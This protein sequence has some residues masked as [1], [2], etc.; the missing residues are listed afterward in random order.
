MSTTQVDLS[1]QLRKTGRRFGYTIAIAINIAMLFVVQNIL[2]WG[3][4][5]FL[6][7][8]FAEVVPWISFSLS[9]SI[10]ANLVY[11]LNDSPPVK[12]AGQVVVNVVSL[13]ATYQIFTVFPFD[14]STYTFNWDVVTRIVLI[15]AMVGAGI[16]A[17]TEAIKLAAMAIEKE[18]T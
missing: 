18:R 9:M 10:L 14:F 12:S 4:V 6:T 5:S 7:D 13:L 11:E 2:A 15:L 8:E 1:P 17:V 16:G 3:W